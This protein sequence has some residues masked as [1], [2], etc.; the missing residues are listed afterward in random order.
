MKLFSSLVL[1]TILVVLIENMIAK[2]ILVDL[3]QKSKE[4]P[5]IQDPRG[6]GDPWIQDPRDSWPPGKT[7]L[8]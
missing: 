2:Y 5:L 6:P 3:D 7:W 4:D 8:L 1:A